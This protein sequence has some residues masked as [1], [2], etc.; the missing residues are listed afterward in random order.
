[1]AEIVGHGW[2]F[3]VER[4]GK[5]EFAPNRCNVWFCVSEYSDI[6]LTGEWKPSLV[7]GPSKRGNEKLDGLFPLNTTITEVEVILF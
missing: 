2:Q 7:T 1:M 4:V 3:Q 5:K 6:A